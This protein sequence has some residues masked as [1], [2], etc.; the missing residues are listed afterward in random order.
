MTLKL[1]LK[2][3]PPRSKQLSVSEIDQ[4]LGGAAQEKAEVVA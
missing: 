1:E 2:D 4:M 3:L